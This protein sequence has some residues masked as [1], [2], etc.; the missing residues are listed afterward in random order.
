[1]TTIRVSTLPS[2]LSVVIDLER[3]GLVTTTLVYVTTPP[4]LND[5]RYESTP[6]IPAVKA[7]RSKLGIAMASVGVAPGSGVAPSSA[8][9]TGVVPAPASVGVAAD[10]PHAAI[11]RA[12][13]IRRPAMPARRVVAVER[14]WSGSPGAAVVGESV[15]WSRADDAVPHTRA[16]GLSPP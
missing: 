12:A 13:R 1:M 16:Q 14:I 6:G 2:S 4:L 15:V 7:P 9:G 11:T 10:P 3:T 5:V 8:V